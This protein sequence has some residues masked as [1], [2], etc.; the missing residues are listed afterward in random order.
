VGH[1]VKC[2]KTRENIRIRGYSKDTVQEWAY[3]YARAARIVDGTS[4][5]HNMVLSRFLRE[6]GRDFWSWS[7][8]N[9]V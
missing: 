2:A 1:S 6:E 4:K 5:V 7:A 9:R 8:G 3:C